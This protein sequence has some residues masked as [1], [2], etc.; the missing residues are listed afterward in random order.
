M[1]PNFILQEGTRN[2]FTVDNDISLLKLSKD[3]EFND[4]I[5]PI[6]LP[7]ENHTDFQLHMVKLVN[8][9]YDTYAPDL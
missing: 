6:A 3:L 9:K 5:Q 7:S 1:H 2:N 4:M 8:E